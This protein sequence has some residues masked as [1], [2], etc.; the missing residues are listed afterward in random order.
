MSIA[1]IYHPDC[2]EHEMGEGHPEQ[3]ARINAIEDR[4]RMAHIF[5]FVRHH[6]A[7]LAEKKY[8][9]RVHDAK[10]VDKVLSFA[11]LPDGEHNYLDPDT[12]ITNKTPKAALRAAGA[13]V[14]ATDLVLGHKHQ[15][16]VAFCNVRPPGHHAERGGAMG[17]CFFNNVAVAAAHAVHDYGLRRVAII[18]FDVHHGNGTEDIFRSEPRILFCSSFQHPFYP[19]SGGDVISD[20]IINVP[21]PAGTG[22]DKFREAVIMHW[23][24]ALTKFAPEMIF[25]SAGF[26]AHAE[27]EMSNFML[28]ETD[29]AWVTK[30][31]LVIAD[32][33]SDGRVVSMLEGGYDLSSLARSVTAHLKVLMRMD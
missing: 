3:P 31:L 20:H 7:P 26:D 13:A 22:G 33:F 2:L 11:S 5:D 1:Y 6:E 14:L 8:L 12:I 25:I 9:T 15:H 4:M 27:D 10:Y 21:L 23:I 17:F 18:D 19:F 24:P 32:K 30:E 16:K 28:R 29:Y